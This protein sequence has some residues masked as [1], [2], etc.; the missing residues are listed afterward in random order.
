[1]VGVHITWR[2]LLVGLVLDAVFYVLQ[3]IFLFIR[4]R[5]AVSVVSPGTKDQELSQLRKELAMMRMI[6]RSH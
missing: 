2:E 4:R 6:A 3:A 1:M 5:N